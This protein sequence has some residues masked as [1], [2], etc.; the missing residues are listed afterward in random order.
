LKRRGVSAPLIRRSV[1][2][3]LLLAA[4]GAT[5]HSEDG[6][7]NDLPMAPVRPGIGPHDARIRVDPNR[8][9]WR[10]VGKLQ[11][12]TYSRYSACTGTL[13]GPATVLTAAHCVFNEQAGQFFRPGA[14]HFLIGADGD[15]FAGHA[16][17]ERFVTGPGYDH[18]HPRE[19]LGSDWAILTLDT[20]LGTPDRILP[21][22][23]RAPET[24]TAITIGGYSEDH[25]YILTA[26]L[27]C[28]VTGQGTDA[29]GH[30]MLRHSCTGT[31]GV[32]GAPVLVEDHGVWSVG[33]ID[34]AAQLGAS[35]GFAVTLDEVRTH[36]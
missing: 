10:A 12:A 1:V 17:V 20:K 18:A 9:P 6:R 5:A 30:R 27:A 7:P 16:K 3:T 13:I 34:V 35:V 8:A 25:R 24:G 32:S 2:A 36:L 14:L 19:S 26:D 21:L 4:V 33:G 31:R 15:S 22:R 11:V 29:S 28:Q 23:D